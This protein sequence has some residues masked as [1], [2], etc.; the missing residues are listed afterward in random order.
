MV[1]VDLVEPSAEALHELAEELGLHE[2]AVEDAIGPRQRPKVDRY[3]THLFLT[4]YH[5]G[6]TWRRR[7]S[8]LRGE[9]VLQRPLADHR[10]EGRR[11]PHRRTS[12]PVGTARRA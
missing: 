3:A 10:P 2:L 1:W 11:L 6:S 7:I 9:R 5:V 4:A 12:S 8:D